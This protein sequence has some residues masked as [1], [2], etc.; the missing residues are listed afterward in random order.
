MKAKIILLLLISI[1]ALPIIKSSSKPECSTTTKI[2]QKQTLKQSKTTSNNPNLK[3]SE[4]PNTS[5][6]KVLKIL[7]RSN[8]VYTQGIFFDSTGAFLYESGG[9]YGQ[10]TL[11]KLNYPSLTVESGVELEPKFFA[12]GIAQ[13][14]NTLYQLTWLEKVILRYDAEDLEKLGEIALETKVAEGW[15]LAQFNAETLIATDGSAKIYF[16]DCNLKLKACRSLNITLNGNPVSNLNA[17]V[18]AKGFLYANVYFEK[19]IYKIDANSGKVLKRYDMNPLVDYEIKKETLSLA[20]L[21]SG[22]VLNGIAYDADRDV[23]LVTGKK[24]G[25]FYEVQLQ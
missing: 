8:P 15:G 13:C 11:K 17:L 9:L 10:S 1:L 25:F 4:I 18:Y 24:W 6:Y 19:A 23:F 14:G 3:K 5:G 12:E 22:D 2:T 20:A 7:K 16:L 21:A